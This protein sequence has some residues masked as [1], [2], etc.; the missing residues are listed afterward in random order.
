MFWVDLCWIGVSIGLAS[1]WFGVRQNFLYFGIIR[2]LSGL[3][4]FCGYLLWCLLLDCIW[5]FL[6][7][8]VC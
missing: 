7:L 1:I 2:G 8:R 5:L 6:N 4:L 3:C